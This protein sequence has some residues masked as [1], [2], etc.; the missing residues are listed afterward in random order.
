MPN[1]H[2]GP[3]RGQGRK[4]KPPEQKFRHRMITLPPSLDDR[5]IA[6]SIESKQEIS[7]MIAKLIS[8]FLT[9]EGA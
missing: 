7:P 2:G 1:Q 8:D 6:W 5:L 3:N 4:P 9:Q